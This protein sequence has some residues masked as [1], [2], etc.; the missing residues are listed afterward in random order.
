MDGHCGIDAERFKAPL[1]I[2]VLAADAKCGYRIVT[3]LPLRRRPADCEMYLQHVGRTL[4]AER[5]GEDRIEALRIEDEYGQIFVYSM[6]DRAC[7]FFGVKVLTMGQ[8][9]TFKCA[10]ALGLVN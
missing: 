10:A 5:W 1:Y 6:Y 2:Q 7:E 9:P 4:P 3:K 8:M